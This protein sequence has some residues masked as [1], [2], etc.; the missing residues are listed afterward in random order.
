MLSEQ[1]KIL[2]PLA[3][4]KEIMRHISQLDTQHRERDNPRS[5]GPEN[6]N[7]QFVD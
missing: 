7:H 1:I 6:L 5:V 4:Y 2:D 3:G